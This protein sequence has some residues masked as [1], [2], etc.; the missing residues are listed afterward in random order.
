MSSF[1]LF[2]CSMNKIKKVVIVGGGTAGWMSAALIKKLLHKQVDVC[3]I[4]SELVPTVGV[5]EASIPPIRAI[6]DVLGIPELDFLNATNAS[7]KLAIKF[8]NWHNEE[9]CYFHTFGGAGYS[10][11]F[12]SFQHYWLYAKEVG[13]HDSFWD[14]DLNYLAI[15]DDRFSNKTQQD[16]LR[17]LPYA[18][19]FDASKYAE[20]LKL[21]STNIGVKHIKSHVNDVCLDKLNYV[22]NLKLKNGQTISGD[23]FI[24]CS[25]QKGLLI[26]EAL[27]CE[28][29]DWSDLLL[30]DRAIALPSKRL[31]KLPLY[32]RSIAHKFGWQWQIPLKHRTGNGIVY[33]SKF[34]SDEDALDVLLKNITEPLDVE[35]NYIK[36]KTGKIKTP[37]CKN[38]V[39]IGLS[40]GFLEPLESTSIYLIQSSIIRLIKL[41][42][43]SDINHSLIEEFN[44]QA[45][46]ELD[47]IRDFIVLHYVLNDRKEAFWQTYR[48]KQLPSSLSHKISLFKES[49]QVIKDPSDIF[50]DSSWVQVMLGQGLMPKAYH[51]R[52]TDFEKERLLNW[53]NELKLVK[54]S[55]LKS[56]EQYPDFLSKCEKGI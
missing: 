32:T 51:P 29:E 25:G 17:D 10:S 2:G 24:D 55:A 8:E 38:V 31:S 7:I 46:L 15:N 21:Y 20:M 1:L 45:N 14:F 5:G 44:R 33:S 48:T 50:T 42:P 26:K 49:G 28:F 23:I 19:H 12:C 4:D 40:S 54:H 52:A 3:L 30:C 39:A 27:G 36:F 11:P 35:P 13:C 41:F 43:H 9:K 22:N 6:N 18:Y 34:A 37:W 56:L 16:K 47:A 53:L